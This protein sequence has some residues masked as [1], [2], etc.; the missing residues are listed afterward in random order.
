MINHYA[1]LGMPPASTL[2][3]LKDRYRHLARKAHPDMGGDAEQFTAITEAGQTLTEKGRRSSYDDMLRLLNR[4]CEKCDG[5]GVLYVQ[6][7]FTNTIAQRCA[8][9]NGEGY[10]VR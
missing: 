4:P 7:S 6:V 2:A 1:V 10:D 9:C 3:E 5:R 8:A